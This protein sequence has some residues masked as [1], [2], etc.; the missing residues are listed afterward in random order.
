[1]TTAHPTWAALLLADPSPC[2]RWLVLTELL[3]RPEDDAEVRELAELRHSDGQIARLTAL[4]RDDG[5]WP[6]SGVGSAGQSNHLVATSYALMQFGYRGLNAQDLVVRRGAAYLF[7]KQRDDGSWPLEGQ[8]WPGGID[9][10]RE[11]ESYSMIPLQTAVPLRALASCG[12]AL[13]PQA[14]RAYDWLVS[15]RLPDGAWP[16]GLASGSLGGVAGYRRIAHSRWGCRTNTTAALICL[17]LHPQH[18][19]SPAA[20]RALDLLLGREAQEPHA[21]G[22]EVARLAG[23]EEMR[24]ALTY[25]ARYDAALMLDLCGRVGANPSDPRVADLVSFVREQQG[26]FGLWECH[27]RPQASRW[28]SFDLLR[29]LF[30][31][32][33]SSDWISLEPRTPFVPYPKRPRRY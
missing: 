15:K 24:G 13:D 8:S 33:G 32:L 17:A 21:L 2:L 18:R 19:N 26:P 3:H 31:L 10:D 30:H 27:V 23:A 7:S 9:R 22:V 6:A 16:T 28:L 4:Q 20:R 11:S 5:S 29:S 14:E 12:F 25:F 1:V